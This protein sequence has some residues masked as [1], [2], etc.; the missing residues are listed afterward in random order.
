VR[1]GGD[2]L[3]IGHAEVGLDHRGVL[4]DALGIARGDRDGAT[5]N[6]K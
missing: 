5:G 4:L 3:F 6:M 1:L 2:F